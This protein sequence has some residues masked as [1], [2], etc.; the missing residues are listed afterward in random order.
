[1]GGEE[2]KKLKRRA[3]MEERDEERRK[4]AIQ[5]KRSMEGIMVRVKAGCRKKNRCVRVLRCYSEPILL[6]VS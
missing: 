5:I 1:M 2:C 4:M 6:Y 3:Q